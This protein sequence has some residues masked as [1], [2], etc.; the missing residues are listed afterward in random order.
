MIRLDH[1]V[2]LLNFIRHPVHVEMF[3]QYSFELLELY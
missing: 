3:F 2:S 1:K